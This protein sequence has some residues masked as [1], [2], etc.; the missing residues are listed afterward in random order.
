MNNLIVQRGIF[1]PLITA[2]FKKLSLQSIYQRL[3]AIFS[4]AIKNELLDRKRFNAP[5][6]NQ[7]TESTK[8][9]TFSVEEKL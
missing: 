1:D 5:K 7:A 9:S 3:N 4:F 2:G 6:L 8:R